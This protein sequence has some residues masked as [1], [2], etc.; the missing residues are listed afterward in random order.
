[1]SFDRFAFAQRLFKV[2]RNHR[3]AFTVGVGREDQLI[4]VRKGVGN[5]FVLLSLAISHNMSK[6]LS[7]STDPS[8]GQVADVADAKTVAWPQI[9][10]DCLGLSRRLNDKQQA[11]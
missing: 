1:V 11:W 10:V 3:F 7:G 6:S 9:L 4:V 8:F 2:P 5:G